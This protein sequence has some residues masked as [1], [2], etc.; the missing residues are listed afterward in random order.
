MIKVIDNLFLHDDLGCCIYNRKYAPVHLRQRALDGACAVYCVMMYLLILGVVT[1]RQLDDLDGN[2]RKKEPIK[3]LFK[4]LFEN[5]G[6]IRDGFLYNNLQSLINRHIKETV[7]AK[8]ENGSEAHAINR[9]KEY[10]DSGKPIMISVEFRGGAH[11]LLAVGYEADESGI[12]NIFCLD[13]SCD[14]PPTSYWNAV[15]ALNQGTGKKYLHKY[16]A[17]DNSS[18]NACLDE[19]LAID[20]L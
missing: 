13:P 3:N 2:V 7:T 10:V 11:A 20:K 17:N 9:I 16:I 18:L 5:R 19:T 12:F 6:L 8:A 14:C 15:V 1:R 4:A